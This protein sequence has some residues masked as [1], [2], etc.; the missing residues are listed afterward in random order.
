MDN[1]KNFNSA[2]MPSV[3]DQMLPFGEA[4]IPGFDIRAGLAQL[5]VLCQ[6]AKSGNNPFDILV[7][8]L[9]S[10]RLQGVAPDFFKVGFSRLP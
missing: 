1:G 9:T 3:E 6:P 7:S 8:L 5:R 2:I 4:Q 10:P